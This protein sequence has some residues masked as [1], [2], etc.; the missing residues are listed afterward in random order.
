MFFK[1]PKNS[2]NFKGNH[3]DA[4][5]M[6]QVTELNYFLNAELM[7]DSVERFAIYHAINVSLFDDS[8]KHDLPESKYPWFRS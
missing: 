8:V 7:M 5:N 6:T 2:Q 1:R 3:M 4:R